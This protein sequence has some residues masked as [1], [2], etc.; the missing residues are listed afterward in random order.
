[1]HWVYEPVFSFLLLRVMSTIISVR[2]ERAA[3]ADGRA[4]GGVRCWAEAA[5]GGDEVGAKR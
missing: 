2:H 4:G 1:M 3:P 5:G